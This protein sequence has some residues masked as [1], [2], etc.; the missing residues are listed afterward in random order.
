MFPRS[1]NFR[2]PTDTGNLQRWFNGGEEVN[3]PERD[4]DRGP[5]SAHILN[6]CTSNVG[7]MTRSH[8]RL[9]DVV[10]KAMITYIDTDLQP[11][12]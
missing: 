1:G 5:T 7:L 12:C 8:N 3:C 4:R 2:L 11:D 10:R 9:T 6:G